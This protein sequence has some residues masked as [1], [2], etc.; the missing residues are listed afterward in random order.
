MELQARWEELLGQAC[1]VLRLSSD[2]V[3]ASYS[4]TRALTDGPEEA[5]AAVTL[6]RRLA[7]NHGLETAELMAGPILTIHFRRDAPSL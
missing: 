5:W 7:E 4:I 3:V 6:A 2:R 1:E